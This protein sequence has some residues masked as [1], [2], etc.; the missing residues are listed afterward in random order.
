MADGCAVDRLLAL[1]GTYESAA[2]LA[3]ASGVDL[4]LWDTAFSTLEE[5]VRLGMVQ[6]A[7]IDRAAGRV[8]R[9][10]FRLG[11]FDRPY[12]PSSGRFPLSAARNSGM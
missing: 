3:L 5:A 12:V 6:E 11:L 4:S 1:T 9:L 10:K 2:A 7:D 8:L